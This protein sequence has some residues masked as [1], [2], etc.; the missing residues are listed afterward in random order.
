MRSG[1]LHDTA[2]A[3][4]HQ[5]GTVGE[6][7]AGA[8][9]ARRA[10]DMRTVTAGLPVVDRPAPAVAASAPAGTE[11]RGAG[12]TPVTDV[13]D[14]T[15][16]AK[17]DCSRLGNDRSPPGGLGGSRAERPYLRCALWRAMVRCAAVPGSGISGLGA[18]RRTRRRPS[19]G[20]ARSGRGE[21]DRRR[22]PV[23][24]HGRAAR[25]R[26]ARSPAGRDRGGT[27][28][29]RPDPGGPSPRPPAVV[30][31]GDGATARLRRDGRGSGGCAQET[32]P[33]RKPW[34]TACARSRTPSLRNS[35]RAWVLTVSSD[36]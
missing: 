8:R 4:G 17:G 3:R 27:A 1:G 31:T 28:G 21:H 12:A 6:R 22:P 18:R 30:T 16:V 13:I 34:A 35:R 19:P 36:R 15:H 14:G 7:S 29:V 23:H 20:A 10:A 24:R 11:H 9:A 2:G 26:P 32:R 25:A 33:R 5:P